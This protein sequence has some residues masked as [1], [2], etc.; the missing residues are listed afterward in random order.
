MKED[1]HQS[2]RMWGKAF[3]RRKWPETMHAGTREIKNGQV[4]GGSSEEQ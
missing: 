3:G 4:E 2:L 1:G